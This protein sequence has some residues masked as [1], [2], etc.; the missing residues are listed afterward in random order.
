MASIRPLP[1]M[2]DKTQEKS[3]SDSGLNKKA[4]KAKAFWA[5]LELGRTD[6]LLILESAILTAF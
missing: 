5:H 4:Q 2:P 3:R 1:A 6:S